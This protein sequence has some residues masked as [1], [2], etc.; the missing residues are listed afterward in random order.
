MEGAESE[1]RV[2]ENT[3]EGLA[4]KGGSS[5]TEGKGKEKGS[6]APRRRRKESE[7]STSIPE[8]LAH[9]GGKKPRSLEAHV[10]GMHNVQ[11]TKAHTAVDCS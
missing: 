3:R 1:K 8:G 10:H 4:Y 7:A 9:L 11:R 6:G 5:T 2:E